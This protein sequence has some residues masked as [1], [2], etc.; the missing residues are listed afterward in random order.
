MVEKCTRIFVCSPLAR[1]GSSDRFGFCLKMR[2]VKAH[3]QFQKPNMYWICM[4]WF[5]RFSH[6]FQHFAFPVRTPPLP[7][8][9]AS[10]FIYSFYF[11]SFRLISVVFAFSPFRMLCAR[12]LGMFHLQSERPS[13]CLCRFSIDGVAL[14]LMDSCRSAL[15]GLHAPSA[16]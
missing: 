8:A 14:N 2:S 12:M 1:L 15:N 5:V 4:G 7:P 3:C 9:P 16:V 13:V 10:F 6:S 11:I